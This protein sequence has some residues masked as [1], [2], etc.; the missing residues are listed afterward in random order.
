MRLAQANM[1][2]LT[3]QRL[4]TIA[5]DALEEAAAAAHDAPVKRT[6][7]L[8]LVLAFLA[9][10]TRHRKPTPRWPFDHFWQALA[11]HRQQD[12][13]ANVNAALNAIYVAVGRRRDVQRVSIF[14]QRA[15]GA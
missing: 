1:Q 6:W 8:R 5:L 9:S 11:H 12:R 2:P 4:V 13:W 15:R 7:A 10:R 3:E 14:E